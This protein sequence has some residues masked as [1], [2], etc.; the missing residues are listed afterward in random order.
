VAQSRRDVVTEGQDDQVTT[1]QASPP[2][3]LV[4][5]RNRV[6]RL[7]GG[8]LIWKAIVSAVGGLVLLGGLLLI[9]LPGPGWAIVFLGLAV[10]AT[11]FDWAYRLLRYA[12]TVLRRWTAWLMRQPSWVRGLIG[13][14]GLAFLVALFYVLAVYVF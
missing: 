1:L 6:R 11:E 3:W 13:L 8:A 10:W 12:R 14:V 7:P 4:P 5:T 2:R 9:P